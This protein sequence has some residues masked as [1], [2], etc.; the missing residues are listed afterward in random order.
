MSRVYLALKSEDGFLDL[1]YMDMSWPCTAK[2]QTEVLELLQLA[3]ILE[4]N[5]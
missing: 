1:D 3:R 5:R 2:I 4:G